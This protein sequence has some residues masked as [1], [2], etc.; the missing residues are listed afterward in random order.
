[1]NEHGLVFA[2]R[3]EPREDTEEQA[4]PAVYVDHIDYERWLTS[5]MVA[6]VSGMGKQRC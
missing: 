6:E 4:W 1:M 3:Y 5:A 2:P